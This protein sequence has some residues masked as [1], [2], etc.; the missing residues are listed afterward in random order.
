MVLCH[1]QPK[2]RTRG[3]GGRLSKA[4]TAQAAPDSATEGRPR[5]QDIILLRKG[6]TPYTWYQA[7]CMWC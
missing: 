1:W 5:P 6:Y 4:A 7:I 2:V 3:H